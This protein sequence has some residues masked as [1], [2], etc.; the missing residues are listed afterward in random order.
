M[1]ERFSTAC[2]VPSAEAVN[3]TY[4]PAIDASPCAPIVDI[5]WAR[6][7]SIFTLHKYPS[8]SNV[9][10]AHHSVLSVWSNSIEL[11]VFG[12]NPVSP[13][14]VSRPVTLSIAAKLPYLVMPY[15]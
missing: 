6:P 15:N 3:G 12:C 1:T 14:M 13:I 4:S 10:A 5:I 9:F 8:P 11:S 7:V 2:G